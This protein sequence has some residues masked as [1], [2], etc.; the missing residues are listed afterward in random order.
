MDIINEYEKWIKNKNINPK[1]NRAIKSTGKIYK[2]YDSINIKSLYVNETID[3]KDPISLNDIWIEED[4]KK[5]IV[6]PD[7]NNLVF[8]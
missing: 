7:I 5:K 6:Y 2:Y 3:S 4:G 1:T 8:S